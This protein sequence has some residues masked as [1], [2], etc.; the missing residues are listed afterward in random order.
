MNPLPPNPIG[1]SLRYNGLTIK[2]VECDSTH[3]VCLF[4]SGAKHCFGI[5]GFTQKDIINEQTLFTE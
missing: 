3:I 1:L 4:P 2:V 5:G